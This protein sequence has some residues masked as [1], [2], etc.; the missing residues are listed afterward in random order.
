MESTPLWRS[1]HKL[2]RRD[3]CSCSSEWRLNRKTFYLHQTA[4]P[5]QKDLTD[6]DA[7]PV[8]VPYSYK[9]SLMMDINV[10]VYHM[11]NAYLQRLD[12]G[13]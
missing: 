4:S 12:K 7:S 9:I 11:K 2:L 1:W 13:K 5:E 8:N 10:L 6:P 3:V